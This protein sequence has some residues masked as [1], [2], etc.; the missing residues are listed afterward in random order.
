MIKY[1]LN[2]NLATKLNYESILYGCLL[3]N[4][5]KSF[6][7]IATFVVKH[8]HLIK[9]CSNITP[10]ET[11]YSLDEFITSSEM[12]TNDDYSY[13]DYK[14]L[15]L[16]LYASSFERYDQV[17]YLLNLFSDKIYIDDDTSKI[18]VE[19]IT[20]L[21]SKYQFKLVRQLESGIITGSGLYYYKKYILI[22]I[23][24]FYFNLCFEDERFDYFHFCLMM[25]T[26][27]FV[28]VNR[29]LEEYMWDTNKK[30]IKQFRT[31]IL[32][33]K[34]DMFIHADEI[35]KFHNYLQK[36]ELNQL[37]F[38]FDLLN[39]EDMEH[40]FSRSISLKTTDRSIIIYY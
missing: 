34:E 28:L 6:E 3:H 13:K 8:I 10:S 33:L 7:L 37:L 23:N 30:S 35:Q 27:N 15:K 26:Q 4:L 17:E 40:C 29:Y 11:F 32:S 25:L 16:V 5:T 24:L 2:P 1:F 12:I 38:Y 39:D 9:F 19:I 22:D 36:Q 14:L 31:F 21:S 20:I 18:Y